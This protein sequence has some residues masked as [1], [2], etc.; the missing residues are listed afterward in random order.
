MDDEIDLHKKQED[1]TWLENLQRNSWEPEVII[2]G[3]ILAF[4]FI[5]PSK[6]Y[7]FS[8]YLIQDLGVGYLPSSLVLL[9]LTMIIS[10]FKIFF[11]VHLSLRFIWAGLLGLSFAFPEGVIQEKLFKMGQGFKY[12]KPDEM[13][14]KMEKICSTTFAYPISLTIVF[15]IFTFYLGVLIVVYVIL[16]LQFL[17]IYVI[18]M[19]SLIF[20]SLLMAS[21]KKTKFKIWYSGTILSSIAAIYQ[22]NLGKWFTLLYGIVI[23]GMAAPIIMADIKDFSL[24]YN[25]TNINNN[26][27][28]W[29]AK[30]LYFE[31]YHDSEKRFAKAFIPKEETSENMLKIGVVRYQGD[32]KIM[33][34][35]KADFNVSLDTLAWHELNET[36]DLH[37][38][39]LNDSLINIED[40]SKV[41]LAASGQKVYQSA[42]LIEKLT[43]GR[44]QIRIEKLVLDYDFF[45]DEPKI[46][47]LKNWA[48]FEFIKE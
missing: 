45:T 44:H 18:F 41:R 2:S 3:I 47:L 27:Q 23:F 26:E 46:K 40:W 25:E 31:E 10:V 13:A 6:V 39:Y 38:I 8:A 17:I 35:I 29:P 42:F 5:F 34:R 28:E 7:E 36:A 37:R 48:K 21:K 30:N 12:Q 22:S 4:L 9:Y 11:V 24:F 15:L 43:K 14:L 32:S 20:F 1:L 16:D 19:L 33:E